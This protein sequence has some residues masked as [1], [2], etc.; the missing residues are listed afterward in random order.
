MKIK[1]ELGAIWVLDVTPQWS[2]WLMPGQWS[3]YLARL[4]RQKSAVEM[5]GLAIL[6]RRRTTGLESIS[7]RSFLSLKREGWGSMAERAR[8]AA[9]H[10]F[11]WGLDEANAAEAFAAGNAVCPAIAQWIAEILNRS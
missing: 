2:S 5:A 1:I 9:L 11:R 10:G 3:H 6:S 8:E 4:I 7:V